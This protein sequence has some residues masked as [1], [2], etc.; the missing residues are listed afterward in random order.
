MLEL[1]AVT[2]RYSGIAAVRNVSFIARAG[3]VTGYLGP[4][5][6]GK[7]TTMKMI[8]GLIE[9]SDGEILFRGKPVDRD[10]MAYRRILGYVPEEPHLYPHLT[11]A[12]YL[13]MVGQLRGLPPRQLAEKIDGFLRLLSLHQDRYV[14]ISAY[15]KGMRQK[16]LLIAALLHNPEL[17]L[18]DEPFSGLDV[19]SALVL[20]SLIRQ[21]AARGKVI[22]FSSHELETVERVCSR[23]VILHKGSVVANDSI[24]QLR[25]LMSLP[26]LE[27]I[28]S[29]LAIE[30]D[31][32]AI[33][34]QIVQLMEW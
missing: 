4:N 5:G 19:N 30:Q 12:E 1:R 9:P 26:T 8:T 24:E 7:S 28:F 22:L 11:G 20:R 13:E 17:V 18:L 2:K 6:S 10:P 3:E 32:P 29:Q 27:D 31:T 25:A 23:V 14:A 34:R 33:T 15:S 21:L 16:V